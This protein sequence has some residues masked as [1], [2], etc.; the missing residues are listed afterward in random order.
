ML[1]WGRVVVFPVVHTL[2]DES[3]C[4]LLCEV[5]RCNGMV[6]ESDVGVCSV[7]HEE[8]D[9]FE[10]EVLACEVEWSHEG[11]WCLPVDVCSPLGE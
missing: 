3:E 1:G 5:K 7:V 6:E 10:V 11:G 4:S 2:C 9:G 8:F